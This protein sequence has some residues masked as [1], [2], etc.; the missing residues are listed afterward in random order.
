MLVGKPLETFKNAGHFKYLDGVVFFLSHSH[1]TKANKSCTILIFE[2]FLYTFI[3]EMAANQKI[4]MYV[5][6]KFTQTKIFQTL[7]SLFVVVMASIYCIIIS[8]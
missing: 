5:S 7:Y 2:F 1:Q 4:S 6:G 8:C 3:N